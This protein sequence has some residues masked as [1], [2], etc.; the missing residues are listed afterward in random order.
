MGTNDT[1][2]G[3]SG[4]EELIGGSGHDLFIVN[5]V[6]TNIENAAATDTVESSTSYTMDP[7][8]D[9][10]IVIGSASVT[11]TGNS[12]ASNVIT[13]NSADDVIYA[14]AENTTVS[15]GFNQ[16]IY[17]GDG[18]SLIDYVGAGASTIYGGSDDLVVEDNSN[19]GN[20]TLILTGNNA[21]AT[22]NSGNDILVASGNSDTLVGGTGNDLFVV[23]STS[24]NA[25]GLG[26]VYGT[27]TIES[28]VSYTLGGGV[29]ILKFS[30]ATIRRVLPT[31]TTSAPWLQREPV[32]PWPVVPARPPTICS[33]SMTSPMW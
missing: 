14:Y 15:G 12:D 33:L 11:I 8:V 18:S 24:D 29:D 13:G 7:G 17:G 6:T 5:S 31:R 3:G 4:E 28:S 10:L 21:K 30:L 2:M 20:D 25:S 22:A 16:L 26:P 19:G 27:D 32:T 23:S 1:L 9:S